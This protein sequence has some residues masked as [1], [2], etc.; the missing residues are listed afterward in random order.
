M[1]RGIGTRYLFLLIRGIDQTGRALTKPLKDM[2]ALQKAEANLGRQSYRLMFAGA[3]FTTFGLLATR[4]LL[5]TMEYSTRGARVLGDF[6][7]ALERLKKAIGE[8]IVDKMGD[9]ITGWID[10]LDALA[11]NEMFKF[12]TGE[13]GLKLILGTVAVGVTLTAGAIMAALLG[14]LVGLLVTAG[15]MAEA[16]GAAIVGGITGTILSIAIPVILTLAIA[17]L[18]W[19][20]L[21]KEFRKQVETWT[22]TAQEWANETGIPVRPSP[23]MNIVYPAG[24]NWQSMQRAGITGA[25]ITNNTN[26]FIDQLNTQVED[27]DELVDLINEVLA[28]STISI[29][30]Y[31]PTNVNE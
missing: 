25:D 17:S 31:D 14:K 22:K 5:R 23:Q 27:E 11:G 20:V 28:N 2:T 30:G 1:A 9:T 15:F 16:T 29:T 10:S 24:M 19:S 21:P 18:V 13:V 6:G 26:I 8:R 7:E 12:L 3:A 4:A